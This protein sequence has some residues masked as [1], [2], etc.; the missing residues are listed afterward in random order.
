MH[1]SE[2]KIKI[3]LTPNQILRNR[4]V[5]YLHRIWRKDT[6]HD[7][8]GLGPWISILK[9]DLDWMDL[10]IR[11]QSM[12]WTWIIARLRGYLMNTCVLD[13]DSDPILGLVA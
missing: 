8:D 6:Y 5:A 13:L 2:R 1:I 11:Q 4:E 9:I 3:F 12:D 10:D 7:L